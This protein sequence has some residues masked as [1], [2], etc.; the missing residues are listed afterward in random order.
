MGHSSIWDSWAGIEGVP[1]IGVRLYCWRRLTLLVSGYFTE[2]NRSTVKTQ[3]DEPGAVT[4]TD[5]TIP[6]VGMREPGERN[7]VM[8]H[9]IDKV[10]TPRVVLLNKRLVYK[11][12]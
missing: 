8:Q 4:H 11:T 1:F 6:K 9:E 3:C 7:W 12:S 10:K 2:L 5:G